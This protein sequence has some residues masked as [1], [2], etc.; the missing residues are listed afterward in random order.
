MTGLT[1][2]LNDLLA[3]TVAACGLVLWGCEYLPQ[4]KQSVLTV[5]IEGPDGVTVEDCTR[6]SRQVGAVLDVEDIFPGNYRLEVSSP[7]LDR[8]LY[9]LAQ[10][11]RYCGE[12]VKLKLSAPLADRRNFTGTLLAVD[13]AAATIEIE[14]EGEVFRLAWDNIAR[15]KLVPQF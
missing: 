10:Y 13:V 8:P 12:Q 9:T 4:G 6:V 15:G 1:Q 5:Y 3:P 7:G 14:S 2:K 11:Q